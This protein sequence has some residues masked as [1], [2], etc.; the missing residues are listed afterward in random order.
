[1]VALWHAVLNMVSGTEGAEGFV[2]AA[3]STVVIVW[4]IRTSPR[5]S[6]GR[7]GPGV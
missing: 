3:V 7:R 2:A 1:V 6:G 4:A 5:P